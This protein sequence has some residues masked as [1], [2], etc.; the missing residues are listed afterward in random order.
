MTEMYKLNCYRK[1]TKILSWS[2]IYKFTVPT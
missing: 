1:T 2:R